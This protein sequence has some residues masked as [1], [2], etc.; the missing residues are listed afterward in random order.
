MRIGL[1]K[2]NRDVFEENVRRV[3]M[4][5]IGD[6]IYFVMQGYELVIGEHPYHFITGEKERK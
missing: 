5:Q 4:P 3:Y 1:S 6:E 2:I